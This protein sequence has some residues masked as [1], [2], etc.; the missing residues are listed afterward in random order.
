VAFDGFR[1]KIGGAA[2]DR[3]QRRLQRVLPGHHDHLHARIGADYPV[4][5]F[6]AVNPGIGQ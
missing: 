2:A 5:K 6:V 3:F 1:E 4:E